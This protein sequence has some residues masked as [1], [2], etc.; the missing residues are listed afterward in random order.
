MS[1]PAAIDGVPGGRDRTGAF[2]RAVERVRRIALD[3]TPPSFD[4]VPD[5]DAAIF[6]CAVDHK[7][8]Y[9]GSHSVAGERPL[10][11]SA[12]MW[13]V[14]LDHAARN[15]G[16]LSAER[17]RAITTDEV[18]T[19]FRI[20][21]E[22]VADPERRARLWRDL[23]TLLIEVYGGS[24]AVLLESC[25][26]CLAGEG[27]L[28]A[29]LAAVR[30]FSDPLAKKSQLFAKICERRGWLSVRDPE[31][32][33]VAADSVLMRLALRSGLVA[34][35]GLDSVR[36]ETR[37]VFKRIAAAAEIAVPVLDDMLWE[38]GRE[39]P[40]LLGNEGGDLREPPRD[41]QS[42]WY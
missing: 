14:G 31:S 17:L 29:R 7:S 26:G 27:G 21:G 35:A 1:D 24:A 19:T 5:A 11:G 8:G 18:A 16:W 2:P 25:D 30:A 32:W 22:T 6:L 33:E 36:A 41:P 39:D 28:F 20:G 3:Y 42:A 34:P 38:R 4:H 10:R 12:L 9:E 15:P 13:A 23:A 40:D 37:T